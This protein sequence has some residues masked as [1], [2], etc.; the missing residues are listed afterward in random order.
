MDGGQATTPV[1]SRESNARHA[2]G[3]SDGRQTVA[4]IES[5]FSNARHTVGN[6]GVFASCD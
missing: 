3:N 2:V 6:S 4:V 1:E 5:P